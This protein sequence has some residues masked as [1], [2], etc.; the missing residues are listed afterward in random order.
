MHLGRCHAAVITTQGNGPTDRSTKPVGSRAAL[1]PQQP[2]LEKHGSHVT[3]FCHR[4][5]HAVRGAQCLRPLGWGSAGLHRIA[6]SWSSMT[7]FV[8]VAGLIDV[9]G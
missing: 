1:N 6:I 2:W 7:L 5:I 4:C 8:R 3:G 9:A